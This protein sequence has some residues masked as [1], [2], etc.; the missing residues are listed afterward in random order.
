M[1]SPPVTTVLTHAR[2][3]VS[4]F[5]QHPDAANQFIILVSVVALFALAWRG[6]R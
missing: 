1:Q 5:A 2:E 4:V 3:I 6:R